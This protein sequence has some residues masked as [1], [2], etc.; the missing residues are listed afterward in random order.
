MSWFGRWFT[1]TKPPVEL[2]PP[3]YRLPSRVPPPPPPISTTQH[4][5]PSVAGAPTMRLMLADG[6]IQDLPG[7]PELTARA[8]YLI[9]SMLPPAPPPPPARP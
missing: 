8:E 6:S 9:K 4:D 7:D 5:L 1:R 3:G 2:D